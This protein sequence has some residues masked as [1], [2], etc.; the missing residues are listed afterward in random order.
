MFGKP[1]LCIPVLV[2]GALPLTLAAQGPSNSVKITDQ[3]GT[4]Q[5][6]RPFTI[7]RV[8]AQGDI[9]HFAQAVVNGVAVTT[10]CDVKT[11]WPDGS[12]QHAM[13]SFLATVGPNASITVGFTDQPAGNNTGAM[14]RSAMLA[15]N[16]GGQI[17]VTDSGGTT[18]TANARQ[19]V[20]DWS[21]TGGDPRVTYWLQ[22]PICTQVV[23]ED[24]SPTLTYDI[25]WDSYKPLHPIFVVTF[26]PGTSAGAKVEMILE[27]MWTTKLEDQTYSLALQTGN[28]LNPTPVY[29]K[30]SFTHI[31]RSRWRKV[32][33]SGQQPGTVSI[34]Y[35]LAYMTYTQVFPNWDLSKTSGS[36]GDI[37]AFNNSDKGDINGHALFTQTMGTTGGRADIG[38]FPAWYVRYLYSMN[39]NGL[40]MLTGM[41]D[42]SAYVPTHQRESASGK[43][44]DSA[45]TVNAFGYPISLDARPTFTWTNSCGACSAADKITPVG[46]TSTN[47]WTWDMAH[48]PGFVFV[49]YVLTGDWYYLEELYFN[50]ANVLA[51]N[52]S[53]FGPYGRGGSWGYM[54]YA[55]QTRGQAW[56]L[57]DVA[58]AAFMAPDGS[59]QKNYFTQK[60]NFNIEIEEGQQSVTN[61]AFPPPD[62]TCAG[63]TPG[64]AANKW[65][66][67]QITLLTNSAS[68][69]NRLHNPLHFPNYGN[70]YS[71]CSDAS[72]VPQSDPNSCNNSMS[73]WQYSYK[74]NVWG[75]IQE[76][77]FSVG[78]LNQTQ[79]KF[80]LHMV[81]DPA[82]NPYLVGA[83]VVPVIK[84]ATNDYYQTWADLLNGYN[85]N[86]GWSQ[87]G[88]SGS[89]STVFNLRTYQGWYLDCP[90]TGS[91]DS[92]V[93]APGYP[94]IAKGAASYLAGLNINDGS[95][96][97]V[98]AWNWMVANVG[99][100]SGVGAN[101]QYAILPRNLSTTM[102]ASQCDLNSD[103]VVDVQDVQLSIN[104][105]L[106]LLPCGSGD[107]VGTGACTVVDV[108]RVVN[109]ALGQSCR[110][111]P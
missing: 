5:G 104:K 1:F 49:P 7:S 12:V 54:S 36:G 71:N 39:P 66:Y 32:F 41:A 103:G 38:V 83:Y 69:G 23:L 47:G 6:N 109:A 4:A 51:A 3:S 78:P 75:H 10:Q 59:P 79:F 58:Q 73:P 107:L 14:T 74:F 87:A 110:L 16:W 50:A 24:R 84:N 90:G 18:L 8:F 70:A 21:G 35:N 97:G 48:E 101:P 105:A 76:L 17:A 80:L 27:N 40:P 92:N 63:Y 111:G 96:L 37:N 29:T 55:V 86:L 52:D 34:D 28:P 94:H 67:G 106:G 93:V 9:P 46:Q 19:V 77:G 68:I 53:G 31:A 98:N 95:L 89:S 2:L 60:L 81:S 26:Y 11:R 64:P 22:G 33:W 57:R 72:L 44:F 25:G 102:A 85:A 108:Q 42:V 61:G 91:G 99:Y 20:S 65:C 43:Y 88:C 13:I 82:Y 45:H 15:A 30:S 56:G 62:P 100:Q